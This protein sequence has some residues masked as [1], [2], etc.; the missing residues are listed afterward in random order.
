[1][2]NMIDLLGRIFLA[3]IFIY[4]AFDSLFY[5]DDTKAKMLEY[6]LTWHPGLLLNGAIF[7]LMIGGILILMGYR[8]GLGAALI[9]LYWL[10][11]TFL[12]YDWWD[13]EGLAQR[14]L[15]I[16][17]MK[18]LAIAG[19]LLIVSVN[20]S[21]KFSIRRLFATAKVPGT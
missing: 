8:T 20:N 14:D 13:A 16:N 6:G 12:L 21:G 5:F 1:M 9:L 17:F 15:A 10:P 11:A 18:N 19:G 2:K 4:D 3:F 7:V